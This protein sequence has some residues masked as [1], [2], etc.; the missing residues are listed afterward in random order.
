MNALVQGVLANPQRAA[1]IAIVAATVAVFAAIFMRPAVVALFKTAM[2]AV[3]LAVIAGGVAILMNDVSL[4]GPPGPVAR[5]RRFLTVDSAATSPSG[6]GAAGCAD[7]AQLAAVA[8]PARPR[9]RIRRT[10][11]RAPAQSSAIVSPAAAANRYPELVRRSYP[12][13]PPQRLFQIAAATISQMPGWEIVTA[14][15]K[16]MIIDA[17][18]KTRVLGFHDDV[19]VVVTRN[20][21][22]DVCSRSR[23]GEPES[24]SPLDFFHGDFGANIGHIKEFYAALAPATNVA[25]RH[26]E[27]KQTAQEHGVRF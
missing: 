6:N 20:S 8:A 17:L 23:V 24:H 9:G 25:Y 10:A 19:R 22:V 18:Y 26:E 5:M 13:I 2:L 27:L 14:D 21:E 16:T 1:E 11:E 7:A 4:A 12:G 3:V 15:P